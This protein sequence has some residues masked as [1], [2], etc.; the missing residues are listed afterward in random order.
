[1][2]ETFYF[3]NRVLLHRLGWSLTSYVAQASLEV[4]IFLPQSLKCWDYRCAQPLP[5]GN[6]GI[7]NSILVVIRCK[8]RVCCCQECSQGQRIPKDQL[9]RVSYRRRTNLV[10]R[11]AG[12]PQI[13]AAATSIVRQI[14][15]GI[16]KWYVLAMFASLKLLYIV[17]L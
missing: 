12:S 15:P 17:F 6:I 2:S 8:H 9:P 10:N 4:T 3:L 7:R 16:H 13:S 11:I 14:L 5:T 1:M